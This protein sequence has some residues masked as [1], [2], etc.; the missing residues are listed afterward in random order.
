MMV[1]GATGPAWALSSTA[2]TP[3][4]GLTT[5]KPPVV[6]VVS[7]K[8]DVVVHN[9]VVGVDVDVVQP[10]VVEVV[11]GDVVDVI[12]DVA[13]AE[14]IVEVDNGALVVIALGISA[15]TGVVVSKLAHST[16]PKQ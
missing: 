6:P 8:I 10:V 5:S 15:V 14:V 2:L 9:C 11:G 1:V 3:S 4:T 12:V 7:A 13:R 16:C